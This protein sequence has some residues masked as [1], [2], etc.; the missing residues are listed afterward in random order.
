MNNLKIARR[1]NNLTQENVAEM[2]GVERSTYTR[3]E[4]GAI[5]PDNDKLKILASI[6]NVSIDFLLGADGKTL[7]D[8]KKLIPVL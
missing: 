7:A 5:Q 4:S 1:L 6:Y 2:L 8:K 3:Y